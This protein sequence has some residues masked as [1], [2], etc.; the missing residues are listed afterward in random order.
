[1][2]VAAAGNDADDIANYFPASY[3]NVIAVGAST[4]TNTKASYSNYGEELDIVAP[5][6]DYTTAQTASLTLSCYP[7]KNLC[8]DETNPNMLQTYSSSSTP[9]TSIGT[10]F[11]APQA[12]AAVALVLSVKPELTPTQVYNLLTGTAT[13]VGGVEFSTQTGYGILNIGDAIANASDVPEP[14]DVVPNASPNGDNMTDIIAF[15]PST[16][17]VDVTP[18][19]GTNFGGGYKGYQVWNSNTG[20][21]ASSWKLLKPSD[22]DADGDLDLIAFNTQT[23][24]IDVTLSNGSNFGGGYK[25]YQVWNYNTGFPTNT[26]TLLDPAD[27]NGDERADIIAFNRTTTQ[28]NVALSDGVSFGGY[29]SQVWNS[30]TSYSTRD[31][32]LL[33]PSDVDG[34]GMADLV[35]FNR[36]STG[37]DVTLSNGSNF[38]GGY[39]GYQVW[40]SRSS[41]SSSSWR[42]L[43]LA[44]ANGDGMADII[45]FNPSTSGVD[46]TPSTGANFGGGYKG[47]Q[48]WNS[49]TAYSTRDWKV[50]DPSDVNGDGK[51]DIIAFNINNTRIDVTPSSGSN[52]GGGY[53]GYQ[54]WNSRSSYSASS[55]RLLN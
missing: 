16:K 13:E 5:V 45:A 34:N 41:Y 12:T 42:L 24:Q 39:K 48:V 7:N 30:R 9:T 8:S 23:T 11:A 47:Y 4:T 31:W 50:L 20:Y 3:T 32:T 35:A 14:P 52:F 40:N 46:V 26:W 10:S 21:S 54:V 25:G 33:N 38:G 37:I 53:K 36:S 49:R 51:A 1:V 28:V 43:D 18:S 22:V 2:V 6:G 44:D 15:N 19:T 55:W 27:V 17:T 29:G